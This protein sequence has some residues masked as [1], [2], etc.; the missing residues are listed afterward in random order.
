MLWQRITNAIITKTMKFGKGAVMKVTSALGVETTLDMAELAALQ[1]IA[2]AD[3]A[4]IDGIT[5]GTSAAGKALVLDSSGNIDTFGAGAITGS[6]SSLGITGQ[7]A[8]Q[9]G[10]I[11]ITGG[12]SS[13][14]GNVG[15][16]VQIVG[17]T[18]GTTSNG[19]AVSL[20][21]AV[22]GT[23][24]AVNGGAVTVA[25]GAGHATSTGVGGLATLQGGASGGGA[26]GNGGNAAVTG[27]AAASTNGSGGA[28]VITPGALAGSG[29]NGG[30]HLRSPTGL[31]FNQ[32]TAA[33]DIAD[34]APTLTVA[35]FINGIVHGNPTTGRAVTTPTGAALS[36]A[37]GVG[38]A[39]GDSFTF[40]LTTIGVGADDIYT[41]TAGDGNVT[42]IGAVTLGPVVTNTSP[43]S[44]LWRFRNTGANTWVGYRNS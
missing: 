19:A 16:V 24:G 36:T 34:T 15:G 5:N 38:L 17:G 20:T 29:V 1:N 3:L 9:G 18:S 8:A 22:S 2:A 12:T 26:T 4:K 37:C 42:F 10:A 30:L 39:V 41:L 28:V 33:S 35:Q 13:T 44:A 14:A 40:A 25:G 43:G 23:T 21:G 32:Q 7:A 11:V 6:D 27:G 31:I